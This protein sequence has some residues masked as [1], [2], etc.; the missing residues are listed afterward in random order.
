MSQRRFMFMVTLDYEGEGSKPD[1]EALR[2]NVHEIL[3]HGRPM[4]MTEFVEQPTEPKPGDTFIR[5]DRL[6]GGD[7]GPDKVVRTN[8]VTLKVETIPVVVH[9]LYQGCTP[10]DMTAKHGV[11][12]NWPT[13]QY[14]DRDKSLVTCDWCLA[15]LARNEEW[16]DR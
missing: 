4:G 8:E 9:Y 10:C 16:K 1:V 13:G 3:Y 5:G 7:Y 2:K 6:P 12:G 15:V 14:W 11:P